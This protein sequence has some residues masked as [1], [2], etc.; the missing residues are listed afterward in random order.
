MYLMITS[1]C[2][3]SCEHCCFN[4]TSK[5]EDMPWRTFKRACDLCFDHG[6][7]IFIGG[8]EP[9]LHPKFFQFLGYAI[10][11]QPYSELDGITVGVITNGSV[12]ESAIRLAQMAE[13]GIIYAGL[14]L[15]QFHDPIHHRVE[16]AFSKNHGVKGDQDKREVRREIFQ[17]MPAGRGKD[18]VDSARYKASWT[19]CA[20]PGAMVKP[21]GNIYNCGCPDA[22]VIG[23][24]ADKNYVWNY[25]DVCYK[26]T[27]TGE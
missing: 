10:A 16:D 14:S 11:T 27:G 9:T 8:G 1:R 12:T 18:L 22:P 20:C 23:N 15:D 19:D 24:I 6:E 2:N 13:A 3:M 5:G 4:C 26:Q 21:N 7:L 25:E 17:I